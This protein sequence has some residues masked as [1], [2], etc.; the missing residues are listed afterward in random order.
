MR[1]PSWLALTLLIGSLACRPQPS[2]T[3]ELGPDPADPTSE[4]SGL[5]EAP[6]VFVEPGGTARTPVI[7]PELDWTKV[8]DR[9]A[10][11][12]TASGHERSRVPYDD[13]HPWTGSSKPMVTIVVFSDYQCPYCKRLDDTLGS[14]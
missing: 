4:P 14:L 5:G 2:A 7:G 3:L 9:F 13:D 11:L 12:I 10:S 6:T 8:D 1:A